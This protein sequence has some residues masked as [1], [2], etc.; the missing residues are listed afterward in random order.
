[1]KNILP[2]VKGTRDFYPEQ[3]AARN[4]LYGTVRRVS[5]S[6]GYQEWE[7]PILESLDLYAAK[8]GEE[9]VNQQSFVF[10]DRGGDMIALRPELTPSLARMVAQKQN[11]LIFP[12]RWWSYGPFWRYERPQRGRTR[13]F[14]QWNIDL[15]GVDSPEA[16]A[17]MIAIAASFLEQVGFSSQQAVILVNDRKL[18]NA[19]LANLGIPAEKRPDFLSLIDRRLKMQPAD[20][21]RNALDLGM[22]QAQLDGMKSFLANPNLWQQSETLLRVFTAVEALGMKDY[23]RYD[24]NIIRGLLYYTSTVFEAFD[25][26]GGVRRAILGGGR[27]DN[28][29]AQVGGDPLPAVGFAM[30]DVVIG[31]MLETLGLLPANPGISLADVLVTVFSPELQPASMKLAADLRAA[32]LK[33]ICSSEP[34]KL[35]RQ[36]K[37][38]D[39]MGL[40]VVL[41]LGP[42]EAAAGKLAVKDLAKGTQETVA[43]SEAASMVKRILESG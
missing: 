9:L 20:W 43:I 34:G 23:V 41:V 35:P 29:M 39:R 1:M 33:V 10:P 6:F 14:F 37:L 32:G 2:P 36:F 4:W 24:S 38:A 12:L 19:Q 11:E 15:I 40:K 17:E 25:L 13:E 7:A 26:T 28:L 18:T 8:S 3:M 22:S 5:E 31:L 42:D 30:G 27:Y 16:D 21:D